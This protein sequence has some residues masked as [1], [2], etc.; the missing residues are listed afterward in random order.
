MRPASRRAARCQASAVQSAAGRAS[1]P[2]KPPQRAQ[3]RRMAHVRRREDAQRCVAAARDAGKQ[4]ALTYLPVQRRLL[5]A[6]APEPVRLPASA[7]G[8]A[9][10]LLGRAAPDRP[11]LAV[12]AETHSAPLRPQ[13]RRRTPPRRDASQ[14]GWQE[15]Q[16]GRRLAVV[17]GAC[18]R[19][20]PHTQRRPKSALRSAVRCAR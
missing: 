16:E 17:R 10:Q 20:A 7:A 11:K 5:A 6:R 19:P 18:A 14:E 2:R 12:D 15:G 4:A 1:R 9:A 13:L 3:Q 8:S